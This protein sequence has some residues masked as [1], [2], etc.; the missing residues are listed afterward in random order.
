MR[1]VVMT[2]FICAIAFSTSLPAL[3][4]DGPYAGAHTA[5]VVSLVGDALVLK[6]PGSM[7]RSSAPDLTL[8]T[9][10]GLDDYITARIKEAVATQFTVVD[11]AIDPALL[12]GVP[13]AILD[14]LPP[15]H[16]AGPPPDI[17]IVAYPTTNEIS[18]DQPQFTTHAYFEALSLT[19]ANGGLFSGTSSML[20]VQYAVAVIDTRSG[21]PIKTGIARL[22]PSGLFRFRPIPIAFC[23]DGVWPQSM[24]Q[25][26]EAELAQ[27]CIDLKALV[28][29]SLPNAL[30]AVGLVEHGTDHGLDSFE[31][32]RRFCT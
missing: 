19:H 6:E 26:T 10:A 16:A 9:G 31:G 21:T 27:I 32:H 30:F 8:Q 24:S 4:G 3:A 23:A 28:A 11:G 1:S 15:M 13:P 29:A 17:L 5:A 18:I 20:S 2:G 22:A 7:W 12:K 14:R 25:V